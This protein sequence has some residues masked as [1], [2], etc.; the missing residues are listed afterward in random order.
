ME[1]LQ[2]VTRNLLTAVAKLQD[3]ASHMLPGK[4]EEVYRFGQA[5]VRK[6]ISS[7]RIK[8]FGLEEKSCYED[9]RLRRSSHPCCGL[10]SHHLR[11]K[12]TTVMQLAQHRGTK[13][14]EYDRETVMERHNEWRRDLAKGDLHGYPP[15]KNMQFVTY[16]CD[17]EVR[18]I[19]LPRLIRSIQPANPVEHISTMEWSYKLGST[20]LVSYNDTYSLKP[21]H[22][23][24]QH[25]SIPSGCKWAND[26]GRMCICRM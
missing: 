19:R 14:T 24:I 6:K 3:N 23:K 22:Y 10:S 15:A 25:D 26:Q 4:H 13:M 8:V 1:P 21:I 7:I 5:Q 20:Q 16:S 12:S 9:E 11:R 17:L 18:P 2:E